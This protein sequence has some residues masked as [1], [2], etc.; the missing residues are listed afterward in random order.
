MKRFL[1]SDTDQ[2]KQ[3]DTDETTSASKR[4]NEG[5]KGHHAIGY[6]SEWELEFPWLVSVKMTVEESLE[7][8]VVYVKGIRQHLL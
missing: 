6:N 2:I 1:L 8:Y 7:C 4:R 5:S 3:E